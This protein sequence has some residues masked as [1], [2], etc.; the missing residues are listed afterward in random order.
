MPQRKRQ[1]GR[2]RKYRKGNVAEEEVK[3]RSMPLDELS[4]VV[5][6]KFETSK[7]YRKGQEELWRAAYDAYSAK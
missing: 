5:T 1:N 4:K 7:D 3:V 2:G 6:E